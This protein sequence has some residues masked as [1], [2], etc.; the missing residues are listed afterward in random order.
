MRVS[1]L[2]AYP[3]SYR[4][5][6]SKRCYALPFYQHIVWLVLSHVLF[7]TYSAIHRIWNKAIYR[8]VVISET[9]QSIVVHKDIEKER[10]SM[11]GFGLLFL[12]PLLFVA[13][14]F[15]IVLLV[16]LIAFTI[17]RL[18]FGHAHRYAYHYSTP[19][20]RPTAMDILRQR[21]ARGEIDATTF[22]Q[23]RERLEA[24]S[25]PRQQ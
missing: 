17:R 3:F 18:S 12:L 6:Q 20:T 23:M 22:E 11:M 2:F 16:L 14:F 10:I 15:W 8:C 1:D 25:S 13:K 4:H 9:V 7:A 19:T 24:S 21:Y 5:F